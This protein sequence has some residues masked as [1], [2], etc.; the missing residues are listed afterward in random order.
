MSDAVIKDG[1]HDVKLVNEAPAE[2]DVFCV[3]CTL[4]LRDPVQLQCCT[5]HLCNS[6]Y[7]KCAKEV[8]SCPVCG[9]EPTQAFPDGA[10]ARIVKSLKVYCI[11][12]QRGC[13]WENELRLLQDHVDVCSCD[14][15]ACSRNCGFSMERRNKEFHLSSICRLRPFKCE[16]C[17]DGGTYEAITQVHFKECPE[18]P[19]DCPNK[20]TTDMIKRKDMKTHILETCP[21]EKVMCQFSEVGC[22]FV[23]RR[24]DIAEHLNDCMQQHLMM[25]MET[26]HH[27]KLRVQ[28]L[29][30]K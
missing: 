27:L 3:V 13:Y 11:N 8:K 5:R 28:S 20:C 29:E 26:V 25:T 4:V 19:L 2:V 23:C 24:K 18:Y 6:C 17:S 21:L 30:D 12:K 7:Q 14:M 22:S 15:I 10:W 16:F 9:T 1:G